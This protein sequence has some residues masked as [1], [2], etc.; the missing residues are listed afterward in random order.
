MLNV[1]TTARNLHISYCG[2]PQGP[3]LGPLLFITYTTPLS[4]LISSLSLNHHLYADVIQLSLHSLNSD[5]CISHLQNTF[6]QIS[7]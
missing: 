1:I 7:S 5:S 4:T 3:V 2:V 6:Q